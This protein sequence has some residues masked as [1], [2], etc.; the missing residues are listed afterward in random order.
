MGRKSIST[1]WRERKIQGYQ[2]GTRCHIFRTH[3]LLKKHWLHILNQPVDTIRLA[4]L[5]FSYNHVAI[6][7]E[8]SFD[9][10]RG[11]KFVKYAL[12]LLKKMSFL[13]V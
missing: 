13:N 1:A 4:L 10:V 9:P 3:W 5:Q 12:L 2:R 6:V 11:N 8:Y 7:D